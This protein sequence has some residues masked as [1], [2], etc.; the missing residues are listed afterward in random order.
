MN[1]Q[2]PDEF[3]QLK[4]AAGAVQSLREFVALDEEFDVGVAREGLV[5]IEQVVIS[6]T[7]AIEQAKGAIRALEGCSVDEGF[8]K[9]VEESRARNVELHTVAFELLD[10][11]SS[12]GRPVNS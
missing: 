4:I 3:Q 2:H 5:Q 1:G 12:K 6:R 11:L 8:T 10:A 7:D 9:L